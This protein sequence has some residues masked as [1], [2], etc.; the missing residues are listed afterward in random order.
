MDVAPQTHEGE[1][2]ASK[3]L[4]P[5][6]GFAQVAKT[7]EKTCTQLEQCAGFTPISRKQTVATEAKREASVRSQEVHV[8]IAAGPGQGDHH[9][10]K[11]TAGAGQHAL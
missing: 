8:S 5:C 3:I 7:L 11:L 1:R 4:A 10:K 9:K 6:P 2:S